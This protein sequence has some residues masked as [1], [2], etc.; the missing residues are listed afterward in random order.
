[1]SKALHGR[2]RPLSGKN[3]Y[4][5][6]LFTHYRPIGDPEW[7]KKPNPEGVPEPVIA[8]KGECRLERVATTAGPNSQLGIVEAVKCD[9]ERLGPY[10]SPA[11]FTAHNG[12]DL[13]DWWRRTGDKERRI[14]MQ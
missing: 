6:N 11:L 3:A 5:V 13:L 9:D 1:M 12:D 2:N 10:V 7:M 14:S 8:V 4:Y